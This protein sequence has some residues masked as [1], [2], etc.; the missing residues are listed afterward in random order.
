MVFA[1]PYCCYGGPLLGI[2]LAVAR[3][4]VLLSFHLCLPCDVCI[5]GDY[6]GVFQGSFGWFGL[7]GPGAARALKVVFKAI[8]LINTTIVKESRIIYKV[9]KSLDIRSILI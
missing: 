4:C 3:D 9:V 6:Q 2:G 7:F 5:S 1:R 8:E